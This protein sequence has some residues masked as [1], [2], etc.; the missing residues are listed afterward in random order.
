MADE[1]LNTFNPADG[2][3]QLGWIAFLFELLIAIILSCSSFLMLIAAW[4]L[5]VSGKS[6]L[7]LTIPI[8]LFVFILTILANF[9]G[10]IRFNAAVVARER[11]IHPENAPI[12]HAAARGPIF[13]RSLV[14]GTTTSRIIASM[15]QVIG[16]GGVFLWIAH[17]PTRSFLSPAIMPFGALL[18]V[19]LV[20]LAKPLR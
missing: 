18:C 8:A 12:T 16:F 3:R 15:P 9:Y 13:L 10:A 7:G 14:S 2:S 20:F 11:A 19:Q 4:F 6:M 17:D 5:Y 1:Q